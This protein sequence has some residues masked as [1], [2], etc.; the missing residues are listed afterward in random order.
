M[1]T[2]HNKDQVVEYLTRLYPDADSG[3]AGLWGFVNS[4]WDGDVTDSGLEDWAEA[5]ADAE[6]DNSEIAA[7]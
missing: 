5:W 6:R 1:T 3:P 4:G 2:R 7:E